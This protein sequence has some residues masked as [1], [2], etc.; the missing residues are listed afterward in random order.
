MKLPWR[1]VLEGFGEMFGGGNL[2]HELRDALPSMC[3]VPGL[4]DKRAQTRIFNHIM[5]KFL[6]Q[7]SCFDRAYRRSTNR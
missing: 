6:L 2:R 7:H 4:V 5:S 3:L 1:A